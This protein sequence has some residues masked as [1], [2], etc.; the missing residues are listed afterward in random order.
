MAG[1]LAAQTE[2]RAIASPRPYTAAK[3][4]KLTEIVNFPI[5]GG[6]KT[7]LRSRSSEV[8]G[9]PA[10]TVSEDA[11]GTIYSFACASSMFPT[12]SAATALTG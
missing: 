8:M 10:C 4:P 5:F 1:M 7:G 2:R 11:W 3:A 9:I 6:S 12:L